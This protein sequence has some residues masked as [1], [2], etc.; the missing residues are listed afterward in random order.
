MPWADVN[1][2]SLRYKISGDGPTVVLFHELGGSAESWS[3]VAAH[4][5]RRFCVLSFDQRGAGLSEKVRDSFTFETLIDDFDAL[6]AMLRINLPFHLVG[7][8]AGAAQALLAADRHPDR[9]RSLV[10]CNPAVTTNAQR[11]AYLDMRAAA[12][13]QQGLRAII[14]LT[15]DRSF[16]AATAADPVAYAR[17]RALYLANDAHCFA[18]TSSALARNTSA[19]VLERIRC[20][21]LVLAGRD[22]AVRPY[23]ESVALAQMIS[24]VQY[25]V[26]DGGHFM[27][28]AGPQ[29]ILGPLDAFLAEVTTT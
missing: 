16:P 6:A 29:V 11:A 14:A 21:T 15:L 23:A 9:V 3:E 17:Y 28:V 18:L 2:V 22:D 4:L 27:H 19:H 25:E 13:E 5:S 1:G 20:K 26:V 12:A 7:I 24:G 8:A 10:L